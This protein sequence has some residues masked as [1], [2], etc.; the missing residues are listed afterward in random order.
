MTKHDLAVA[1]TRLCSIC[2]LGWV[3]LLFPYTARPAQ[4][5]FATIEVTL[6]T[7]AVPAQFEHVLSSRVSQI[8]TA[9]RFAVLSSSRSAWVMRPGGK[10]VPLGKFAA[11]PSGFDWYERGCAVGSRIVIGVGNYSKQQEQD[12]ESKSR[13]D[14]VMGPEPFGVLVVNLDPPKITLVTKFRVVSQSSAIN[15]EAVPKFVNPGF[16]SCLWTGNEL[17]VGDF[18]HL[19]RLDLSNKTAD[20]IESDEMQMNRTSLWKDPDALW[21]TG[22]SGAEGTWVSE[23]KGDTERDYTPLNYYLSMPDSILRFN[24]RLLISS[25]AGVT[26]IDTKN[27]KYYHYKLTNDKSK[28]AV[29]GLCAIN[30]ELWGTTDHGWVKFDLG[31]KAAT[32][33]R[34]EGPAT[35]NKIEALGFFD[36]SWFVGTDKQLARIR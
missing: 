4:N 12:E 1:P 22:D 32:I 6:S 17:Y 21:Y 25:L 24:G 13:G 8:I 27:R 3:L 16:E 19:F 26:E 30:G 28:M 5:D 18:G 14:F 35:S 31:R 36:G 20:V 10:P 15:A 9:Q 11:L 23:L 29:F 7:T 33:F 34:L 2:F